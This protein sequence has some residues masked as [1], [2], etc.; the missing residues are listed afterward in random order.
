MAAS[1]L[2]ADEDKVILIK[3]NSIQFI[4]LQC[5][6]RHSLYHW[7]LLVVLQISSIL[8]KCFN[9]NFIL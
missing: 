2:N 9:N 1:I 7:Q 4:I 5:N 3:S 8:G 6:T